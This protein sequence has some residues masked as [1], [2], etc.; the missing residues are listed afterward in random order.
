MNNKLIVSD[1]VISGLHE[2][3]RA[4][5]YPM[6]V[7]ID[8]LDCEVTKGITSLAQSEI[9]HGHDQ[10]LT[11]INVAFDLTCSLKMWIEAERYRFLYFVSSQ[12]T[13]HRI[14]KFDIQKQ[15]NHYVDKRIID[16][17]QEKVDDYNNTVAEFE[18]GK[19]HPD[20]H[21]Q[22]KEVLRLKYLDVLYNI[23]SGFILTARMTTNYRELKTIY[24]QRK[25]H[26]LPEWRLFCKWIES[27]PM[28]HLITGKDEEDV[29]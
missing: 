6:S 27:L 24:V 12:S 15:C 28:S 17:L 19:V 9:G 5:K 10:F 8:M 1:V 16:I 11:G 21:P 3:I 23:P 20:F 7:D 22:F 29:I 18:A 14:T 25:T 26:R 4:A 2:S 13:M